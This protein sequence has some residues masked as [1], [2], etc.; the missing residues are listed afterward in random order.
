MLIVI[1]LCVA[2]AALWFATCSDA[3]R[4][5]KALSETTHSDKAASAAIPLGLTRFDEVRRDFF[6]EVFFLS[7]LACTCL[8]I[9]FFLV[10]L[11]T[12]LNSFH[13]FLAQLQGQ[14]L[15]I[16]DMYSAVSKAFER[17]VRA[18]KNLYAGFK[19]PSSAS[20]ADAQST[21]DSMQSVV[22]DHD[23]SSWVPKRLARVPSEEEF[24]S[25]SARR[26]PFI[27]SIPDDDDGDGGGG[28]PE[29]KNDDVLFRCTPLCRVF[30]WTNA[31]CSRMTA[32]SELCKRSSA[33]PRVALAASRI[34]ASQV[35]EGGAATTSQGTTARVEMP[36]CD[37]LKW[38]TM[39]TGAELGPQY[40]FDS[41]ST[42][43]FGRSLLQDDGQQNRYDFPLSL[44]ADDFPPPFFLNGVN[45][46]VS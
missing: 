25:Y 37:F 39:P 30:N 12:G 2:S 38:L 16:G 4:L 44:L 18:D 7:L 1:T 17:S 13:L 32:V 35:N 24:R 27:I 34:G 21:S 29:L 14:A 6:E 23:A 3:Y 36:F 11:A 19:I 10:W 9:C 15:A 20:A 40:F 46:L 5:V 26:E 43:S 42:K 45:V 22:D 41:A 8:L 33:M 28:A 31:C